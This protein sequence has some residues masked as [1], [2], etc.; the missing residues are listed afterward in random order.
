MILNFSN[1]ENYIFEDLNSQK[2]LPQFYPYFEQW[3]L[4]RRL[5]ILKQ[6]GRQAVLD[7]LNQI[8]DEDIVALEQYFG[9]SIS[10][11]KL[12]YSVI[13]NIQVP[14]NSDLCD[15]LCELRGFNYFSTWRDQDH[16]YISLWR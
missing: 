12:E 4:A 5:P 10:I 11:D 1:I 6:L 2:L 9:K 16:I 8:S 7:V 15:L 13:K 14:V 3:R